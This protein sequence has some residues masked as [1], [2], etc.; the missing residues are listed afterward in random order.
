[1]SWDGDEDIDAVVERSRERRADGGDDVRERQSDGESV[2]Q[3]QRLRGA[4][5][6]ERLDRLLGGG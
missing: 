3:R 4:G 1:M 2:R 6:R 5:V